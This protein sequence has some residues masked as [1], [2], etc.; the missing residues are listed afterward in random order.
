LPLP[1]SRQ[2][3]LVPPPNSAFP[4]SASENA[5]CI[6]KTT[7]FKS[8]QES[9]ALA[10]AGKYIHFCNWFLHLLLENCKNSVQPLGISPATRYQ[11]AIYNLGWIGWRLALGRSKQSD[12]AVAPPKIR[13]QHNRQRTRS[14]T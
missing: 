10:A 11:C 3:G 8:I 9:D 7:L 1:I 5:G 4:G 6:K 2:P 13:P 12:S 14:K